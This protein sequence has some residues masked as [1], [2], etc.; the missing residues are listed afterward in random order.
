M[1]YIKLFEHYK[2]DDNFFDIKTYKGNVV[3]CVV[4]IHYIVKDLTLH[5]HEEITIHH[6]F[7]SFFNFIL[8]L[9]TFF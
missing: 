1:K 7:N 6:S 4:F 9:T 8:Y 3:F 2:Q 5:H